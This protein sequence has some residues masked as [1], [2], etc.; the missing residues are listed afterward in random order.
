MPRN[1]LAAIVAASML[2]LLLSL[3]PTV[4]WK[5]EDVPTF[6][7][8]RPVELTEQNVVDLFTLVP[9]HYNIKR[10]KWENQSVF[11]DFVVRPAQ[12]V[13]LPLVYR[14]F[15]TLTYD[16]FHFTGNTKQIYFRLLEE[17]KPSTAKLLVAIEAKRT[18]TAAHAASPAD[19]QDVRTH[20]EQRFPVRI[21]PYF[22]ERV[23]P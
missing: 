2:A 23:S 11:V 3:V 18:Q 16:L 12:Q 5:G 7:A 9:T 20:V 21:D 4:T 13:D 1:L 15:Y 19:I 6:Q 10:V 8:S 22:H 17:E 14:D